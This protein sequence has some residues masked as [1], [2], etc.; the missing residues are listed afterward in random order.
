[1]KKAYLVLEN[2]KIFEGVRIG[3]E[4]DGGG[5]LVF[6]TG[7][8]G[9]PEMLTD[10]SY[11]GQILMQ[12]FPL[13]GNYGVMEEDFE[14]ACLAAGYVVHACCEMP[15][16][17]R[18]EYTLDEFLKRNG[19]PG[20]AGVD[21]REITR[22]IREEGTMYARI[23]DF[24][25]DDLSALSEPM[26]AK[27]AGVCEKTVLKAKD[28]KKYSV[29]VLDFGVLK[30]FSDALCARGCEVTLLPQNTGAK[31]IL[32]DRPDGVF[33]GNGPGNPEDYTFAIEE[34]GKLI[35][36]VPILGV[37][38]GHQLVA[39][40]MGGKVIKLRHGH[41][42]ANQPAKDLASGRTYITNQNH[43]YA[44]EAESLSG[45]AEPTFT[46]AHD[47][48]CE[49]LCYPGKRCTTVQFYPAEYGTGFI[50]D[51]FIDE[52]GGCDNA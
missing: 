19:V 13:A 42:G 21:T 16:N 37:G 27:K 48:T 17:F 41:R 6:H 45:T 4:G 29:T 12:T 28:E 18:T 39:L 26:P 23:C 20:I 22:I 30:S 15:S 3:A 34:I 38:L 32:A 33:L 50:W 8:V 49:G 1:M 46:N 52:M 35:G 9:Y 11:A 14:G 51:A 43:G 10:P 7:V 44:V 25:P 24:V 2:G 5:E 47:N 40:A 31:E 36:R